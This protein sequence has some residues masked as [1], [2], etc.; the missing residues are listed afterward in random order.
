[1]MGV[2]RSVVLI[3]GIYF[4]AGRSDTLYSLLYHAHKP[5]AL[6]STEAALA[7][8]WCLLRH[9]FFQVVNENGLLGFN[10][11]AAI[12]TG[13]NAII[14]CYILFRWVRHVQRRSAALLL[15]C[16]DCM[17]FFLA[18]SSLFTPQYLLL[19]L[20]F[21]ALAPAVVGI[22]WKLGAAYAGVLLLE[23][24]IYPCHYGD[25]IHMCSGE[26]R[27]PLLAAAFFSGKALLLW[28]TFQT[29]S[30]DR[31]DDLVER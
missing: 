19:V 20:G 18:F 29:A 13:C 12:K 3:L 9:S 30:V 5:L 14:A 2:T 10:A 7:I 11:P 21:L 31:H 1:L 26:G 24:V 15:P 6:E 25:F 28:M 4:L 16:L 23:Q 22:D 8:A 17:L 27:F